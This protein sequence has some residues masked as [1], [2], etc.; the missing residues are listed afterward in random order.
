MVLMVTAPP[1]CIRP[2]P[3]P[4]P[5]PCKPPPLEACSIIISP[6]PSDPT[7]ALIRLLAPL[8]ILEPSVSSPVPVVAVTPLRTSLRSEGI[9]SVSSCNKPYMDEYY[10]VLGIS[11]V[12][13]NHLPLNE[14]VALSLNLLLPLVEDVTSSLP[15]PQYEDLTLPQYEDV[16]LFYLLLVPLYEVRI[17]TFVLSTLV[18]M[19]AEIDAFKNGGFGWYIHGMYVAHCSQCSILYVVSTFAV[20]TLALPEA[21]LARSCA[22]LSKLQVFSDSNVFFSALH[23]G[24][25][26]N[27]IAGCLLDITNLATPFT[28]LSFKFYQCTAV[29]LAVAF[30][31]Y[32]FFRLC[33]TFTLFRVM[34]ERNP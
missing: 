27:G 2:P 29:C 21:L 30:A 7:A 33:F 15:L 6:E 31:M 19:V 4:P 24:M 12:K 32:V 8:H 11:C 26:L 10:L 34:N 18:S 17:R 20:E 14:D 22:G 25:D 13:M 3:D 23:S 16:T 9:F 28:L 5:L 1:S